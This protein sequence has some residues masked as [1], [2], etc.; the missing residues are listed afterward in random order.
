MGGNPKV[1]EIMHAFL[2]RYGT[3]SGESRNISGH[4]QFT[5]SLEKTIAKLHCK[6]A[7]LYFTSGF[8]ANE[9]AL[10]VLGSQLP[11]CVF[12]SDA[13]NHSSII[14]GIRHSRA[15]KCVW[16]HNCLQDLEEKLASVPP[17]IPKII[18]FESV[19]SISGKR[20]LYTV[21][22][23]CPLEAACFNLHHRYRRTNC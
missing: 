17:G 1:L 16:K 8:N 22:G 20:L 6:P 9:C 21:L 3:C 7:A 19:Y 2:D 13:S 4:N 15:K 14:E 12:F 10:T 23:P 5:V 11:E 18:F